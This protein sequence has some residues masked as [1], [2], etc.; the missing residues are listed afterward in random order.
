MLHLARTRYV[1]TNHTH[2][3]E[4]LR[5]Y[6][7]IDIARSTLRRLLV[8]A[9]ENSPRG[10]RPPKHRSRRQRM[11]RE[12]MLIQID[13]SYHRWLGEDGPQF[14]LLLA[15]DDA[16]GIVAGALFC[17]LEKTRSYFQLL[18]A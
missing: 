8:S 17:E 9:G 10:R 6:E 13:G 12:G 2:M 18:E 15:V 14:T 1:G 3:S 4:L 11:P 5:E 16:T 7:G